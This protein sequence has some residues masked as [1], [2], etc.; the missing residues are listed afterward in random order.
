MGAAVGQYPVT[1]RMIEAGPEMLGRY[2]LTASDE[3]IS[4]VYQTMRFEATGGGGEP[5]SS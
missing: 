2:G 3:A 4:R 1:P 5:G